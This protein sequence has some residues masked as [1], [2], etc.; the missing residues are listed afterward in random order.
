MKP[1]FIGITGGTGSGKTYLS[2]LFVKEFGN[3][4]T[5]RVELDSYYKD[6]SNLSLIDRE[7]INYDHPESIDRKLIEKQLLQLRNWENVQIP[8]YNFS[9]HTRMSSKNKII[10]KEIIIVDGI[11]ALYFE[12]IYELLDIKIFLNTPRD[13]SLIRRLERDIA[14]RGRSL[15]STIEQYLNSVRP[16]YDEYIKPTQNL[17][18]IVI[19][20]DHDF[21]KLIDKVN[22]LM[23]KNS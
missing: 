6:N 1:T 4:N 10:P 5:S 18:D 2:K 7:K 13:I 21:S 11:F 3:K 22:F 15:D 20:H 23:D 17:A 19:E 9:N 12:E 8:N 16:M 14:H